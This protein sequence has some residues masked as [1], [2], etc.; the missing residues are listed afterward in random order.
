MNSY[1]NKIIDA[2]TA[3]YLALKLYDIEQELPDDLMKIIVDMN[4]TIDAL[5]DKGLYN[6]SIYSVNCTDA[7]AKAIASYY[8]KVGYTVKILYNDSS[9]SSFQIFWNDYDDKTK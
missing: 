4:A 9:H 7:E 6:A 5:A 8:A 2:K 1:A 3:K